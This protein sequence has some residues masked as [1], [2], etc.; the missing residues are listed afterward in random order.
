[1]TVKH[2]SDDNNCDLIK[3]KLNLKDIER[4]LIKRYRKEIWS[5]FTRAVRDFEMIDEN[6]K[7]AVCISGGKDS[8]LLA[9]LIEELQRHGKINFDVKYIAMDPGYRKDLRILL[10]ENLDYLKIPAKIF[11]TDIFDITG[12]ISEEYPCYMCARMRRGALYS[13]AEKLGA[14]KIAL[15]HHFN[16]VIETILLN[17]FYT[18]SFKTMLPKLKSK[19]F[20]NMQLIR[21]LY[22][23]E[24]NSI[25]KFREYTGLK[26]LDC[27]C[28]VAAKKIGSKRAEI[29]M[30]IE[31][32]RENIPHIDKNILKSSEN[33]YK[34]VILGYIDSDGKHSY[35]EN[36]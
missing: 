26:P 24:E 16:D 9:K 20:E 7:V 15:G 36:Y 34:D 4:S 18:G 35:L 22:Y 14:N 12:E 31:K 21:P 19:N 11:E 32:L 2:N 10:E 13:Y 8:L 28:S 30:I 6:D 5:E 25:I 23:V 33:I 29:K 1:M 3:E 27:A 17:M